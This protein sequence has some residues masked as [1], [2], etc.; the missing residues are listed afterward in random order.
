[1]CARLFLPVTDAELAAF[2][3][4]AVEDLPPTGPRYN[5][6][7]G[8]DVR[9]LQEAPR[10]RL[11]R[12][13]LVP[14]QAKDPSATR[15]VNARSETAGQRTAFRDS[16]RTRRCVVPAAG[17]FEW[18]KEGRLRLPYAIRADAGLIGIAG[19]WDS[20]TDPGGGTL[21]SFALL[22]TEANERIAAVHDRMPVILERGQFAEWLDPARGD[23][24]PFF[25][26]YPASRTSLE[27]VSTR[28]N[29]PQFDD[30]ACLRPDPA[31][32]TQQRLF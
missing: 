14:R 8:Q 7:P 32:L 20:W 26:P 12:W 2:L 29:K 9:V 3:D 25:E 22:T 1:M 30:P 10:A 15:F 28:V 19:L 4:M 6:A 17:F 27:R 5:I 18:K 31:E 21:T 16:L 11:L 23:L 13:G 24:T